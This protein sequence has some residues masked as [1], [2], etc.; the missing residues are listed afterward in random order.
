[1]SREQ[2][3]PPI[4]KALKVQPAS[5]DRAVSFI[6]FGETTSVDLTIG[7]VRK[8]LTT[9]T[10]NGVS[11][12][13]S[14]VVKFMML[15]KARQLN[16]WVG[17]AYLIGYDG[18]DGAQFS[19][20]TSVQALFKR[21][22]GCVEFNGI[23]SG[24]IITKDGSHI[25]YR[26]G[27]FLLDSETLLGGWARCYRTD[28]EHP[29]YEALKLSTYD[30]GRSQWA[31]DAAGMISKCA[32]AAVLRKAFPTQTGGMYT[33]GEM[34]HI[35]DDDTSKSRSMHSHR[36]D[37]TNASTVVDDMGVLKQI[38]DAEFDSVIPRKR[39]QAI[40][41][42]LT[43][44]ESGKVKGIDAAA[45]MMRTELAQLVEPP[46]DKVE[47]K[48]GKPTG[49]AKK[50]EPESFDEPESNDGQDDEPELDA[51]D[52]QE[53]SAVENQNSMF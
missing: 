37:S 26:P 1:M 33:Q 15:C 19:L 29:F 53:A 5:D 30:T 50:V 23:E 36:K 39:Q 13:D 17:D 6:P 22:E 43:A 52:N 32:E 34:E 41:A 12:S 10:R 51:D 11:P 18:R 44:L 4:D 8:F 28:R 24:I 42:A 46:A 16:P 7:M 9:P 20:I 25:E 14:D 47:T 21:A 31:K 49:T 35:N 48:K 40:N 2:V 38:A 45:T 3:L 27:E